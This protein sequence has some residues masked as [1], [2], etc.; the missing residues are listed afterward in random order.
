[1][2]RRVEQLYQ[3]ASSPLAI[4]T[5]A[6]IADLFVGFELVDPGL[7]YMSQWHP[8]VDPDTVERRAWGGY[9]G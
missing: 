2:L 1:M 7:V 4:R 9:A 8:E 3:Q 6:Q 5:H